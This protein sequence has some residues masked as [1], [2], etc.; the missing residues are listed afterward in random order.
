MSFPR[1]KIQRFNEIHNCTPSPADYTPKIKSHVASAVL[2]TTERFVESKNSTVSDNTSIH[3]L[4]NTTCFR[5]PTLP[6][7]KKNMTPLLAKVKSADIF[8]D[9]SSVEALNEK[10]VECNNKDLYI[11][12]LTEQIEDMKL[13]LNKLKLQK[14]DLETEKIKFE[15]LLDDV[16]DK[17]K[18]EIENLTAKHGNELSTLQKQIEDTQAHL[19]LT[20]KE[21]NELKAQNLENKCDELIKRIKEEHG[22]EL[23]SLRL[24]HFNEQT[25]LKGHISKINSEMVLARSEW[26]KMRS[27]NRKDI[28]ELLG[29]ISKFQKLNGMLMD[30]YNEEIKTKEEII[31]KENQ[32]SRRLKSELEQLKESHTMEMENL[33]AKHKNEIVDV[34]YEMLKTITELQNKLDREKIALENMY[35]SKLTNLENDHTEIIAKI[36]SQSDAQV[37][38]IE[39]DC[40]IANQ[41]TEVHFQEKSKDIENEWRIR[42][43]TQIHH[44]EKIIEEY[45]E[46]NEF[47]LTQHKVEKEHLTRELNEKLEEVENKWRIKLEEQ[48]KESDAILK[49]CQAISEYNI[50][51]CEVEKNETKCQLSEALRNIENEKEL[52]NRYLCQR[53]DVQ[54]LYTKLKLDYDNVITKLESASH[55]LAREK[56]LRQNETQQTIA[57]KHT[58]EVTI[59]KTRKAVEAL[60]KR[61]FDSDRD[62][63]Q[64]KS[65]L[66][67][68]EK[69]K[70]ENEDKCNKL[71]VE[72]ETFKK[73]YEDMELQNESNLKLAQNQIRKLEKELLRKVDYYKMKA[74][75]SII[76]NNLANQE[77]PSELAEIK[78]QLHQQQTLNSEAQNLIT[79]ASQELEQYITYNKELEQK[80]LNLTNE[81]EAATK[82]SAEIEDVNKEL[83]EQ[84]KNQEDRY[85]ELEKNTNVEVD[86]ENGE[87]ESLKKEMNQLQEKGDSYYQYCEYY[88]C[89]TSKYEKEIEELNVIQRNYIDQSGKYDELLQKYDELLV[90]NAELAK[91]IVQQES[92][93]GPFRDQLEA[94][95]I[96]RTT[97][98]DQKHDAENEAK[99]M[100]MKYAQILG[101][102]NQK[103]KIKHL[104]DLKHKNFELMENKAEIEQKVRVQAKTI[105]KLKREIASLT[106]TSK[107]QVGDDKENL[108]SPNRS[109]NNSHV[110]SPLRERN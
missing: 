87:I 66:E 69:E 88:K 47:N 20:K 15:E 77:T 28:E 76:E 52:S 101:H 78:E 75:A 26:E 24:E 92:L 97:L 91:T 84:L 35:K 17:Q 44:T 98:L 11:N 95:E 50:I 55:E 40:K 54:D 12:E 48:T 105:E 65:E 9:N 102:Q 41:L 29:N 93:I 73:L 99:I 51:Q 27:E 19:E 58:F 2:S 45:K 57:E 103:Q 1:A 16:K 107:R 74:E 104:I 53:D 60:T 90:R 89:Q 61:L 64:L 100:G 110:F 32:A 43:E 21:Y 83:R 33:K 13:Q 6:K 31:L 59:T 63:E 82:R 56:E 3:S 38:Q 34:E 5:T 42:L 94:Y 23:E 67:I 80:I 62:V 46:I 36:K 18:I 8:C 14:D 68:C 7:K 4:N 71:S 108:N 106:K 96:E 37:K 86:A 72:L 70:L 25:N 49:E 10:I 81:L 30:T 22:C 109:L 85:N 39:E 79:K